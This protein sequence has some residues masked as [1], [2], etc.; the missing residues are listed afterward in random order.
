MSRLWVSAV[1]GTILVISVGIFF[2]YPAFGFVRSSANYRIQADSL[3]VGGAREFSTNYRSEE[4]IGEIASDESQSASYKIRAGYQQMLETYIAITSPAD[5]TMSPDIPGI[6]GGSATGSAVWTVTT[7]NP[8]GYTA[9][10]NASTSPALKSGADSF[11]DYTSAQ[12]GT[13]DFTWS[14]ASSASEFGF[15]PEGANLVQK[16]LDNGS[17][18]GIGSGDTANACWYNLATS[19]FNIASSSSSNHPGGTATNVKFQAEVGSANVQPDGVYET[20]ITVT[21]TAN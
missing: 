8:A 6:G 12:S 9:Y 16:F 21:A 2:A 13:P 4:T 5:V 1:I 20:T 15:T 17:S 19:T 7:D 14:V 11:A 10:I 3:N 18:C